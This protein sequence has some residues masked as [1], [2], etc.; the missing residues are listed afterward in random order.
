MYPGTR[1]DVN[2]LDENIPA[3]QGQLL[4]GWGV[5]VCQIGFDLGRS[6]L[7]DEEIIPLLLRQ[8]RPTF[9]T[10]DE[11]FDD[12]RLCHAKYCVVYLDVDKY[13]VATFV[14]RYLR[15]P[16]CRT[17]AQR[18]GTVV[19]VSSARLVIWRLRATDAETL[20][21]DLPE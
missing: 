10:R 3:S 13:E 6:G 18:M 11:D 14:R 8:R 17:Q 21:W 4:Q 7:Q 15:H 5:H 16:A 1:N 20:P 19:R 9:F 12:R 2:I